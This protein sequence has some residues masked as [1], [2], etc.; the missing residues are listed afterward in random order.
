MRGGKKATNAHKRMNY[1]VVF[2]SIN[3]RQLFVTIRISANN[4]NNWKQ[5]KHKWQ[6]LYN[7]STDK[8]A[9]IDSIQWF[10][11]RIQLPGDINHSIFQ[12]D[13]CRNF[14]TTG[15][16]QSHSWAVMNSTSILNKQKLNTTRMALQCIFSIFQ[17]T[18]WISSS[19]WCWDEFTQF[20][21]INFIEYHAT[22]F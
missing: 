19:E 6:L 14:A 2:I 15:K 11:I 9:T 17:L 5:I 22:V 8:R 7:G 18:A 12:Y 21:M 16:Y 20:I 4:N 3:L 10:E 13:F 1:D